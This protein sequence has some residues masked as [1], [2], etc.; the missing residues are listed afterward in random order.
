MSATVPEVSLS[1]ILMN[2]HLL[3]VTFTTFTHPIVRCALGT[4]Q[5][6]TQRLS[7]SRCHCEGPRGPGG[8]DPLHS[9]P[10]PGTFSGCSG[11]GGTGHHSSCHCYD[12]H[13][14]HQAQGPRLAS[15]RASNHPCTSAAVVQLL[16][17]LCLISRRIAVPAYLD[18]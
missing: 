12:H 17:S 15:P 4:S 8:S 13:Q 9:P 3:P 11:V 1:L 14:S 5:P 16:W 10:P 18:I 7:T 6:H 2:G